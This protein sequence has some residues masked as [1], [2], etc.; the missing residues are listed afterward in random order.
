M[1]SIDGYNEGDED[2]VSD[3]SVFTLPIT[4]DYLD[5]I[6]FSEFVDLSEFNIIEPRRNKAEPAY[7]TNVKC[8]K[9]NSRHK[10]NL[11]KGPYIVTESVSV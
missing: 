4:R 8:G 7:E 2:E 11:H 9:L 1:K 3:S 5:F 10:F 6:N